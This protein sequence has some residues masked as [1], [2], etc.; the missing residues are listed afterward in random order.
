MKIRLLTILLGCG[1]ALSAAH[2][3]EQ[4]RPIPV[5]YT[6][7]LDSLA[8]YIDSHGKSEQDKLESLYAWITTKM[9]YNVYPTFVSI[10]E[11]RDEHK[12][13]LQA[14]RS[15]EGVCRHF[16]LIF[17][18]V[19]ERMDIPAFFIE[20][21]TKSN[22]TVT[23]EPHAWCAALVGG[24]WR[25]YD[26]T[27]G[28]GHVSNYRFVRK[29]NHTYCKVKPEVFIRSHMPFDPLWQFLPRPLS[30]QEFDEGTP[31]PPDDG[32]AQVFDFADTL[33][34]YL[35]QTP[36][37][38]LTAVNERIRHNGRSNRLVDYYVQLNTSNIAVHRQ[39]E[40]YNLYKNA[41]KHYNR[42]V[43]NYN[44]VIRYQ[45]VNRKIKKE[46][47]KLIENWLTEATTAITSARDIL[48]QARQVPEQYETAVNNLMK[49][50]EDTGDKIQRLADRNK[51][52]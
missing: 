21:Y 37:Q 41:L 23:P 25:L 18:E 39:N 2:G 3:Q 36:V 44:E 4:A 26:P 8:L 12:E 17:R 5:A 14:L 28:M 43:D 6:T 16:A 42:S 7:S 24:Q 40:V 46:G 11:K 31:L 49:A 30:F 34:T 51:N 15:R 29:P 47:K 50:I 48:Q 22:G 9:S 13:I 20:G 52:G 45:R 1:L 32:Q 35:R 19:S 10:N 27:F 33:R 38:R